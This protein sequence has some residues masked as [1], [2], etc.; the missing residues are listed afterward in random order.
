MSLC[1]ASWPLR[2]NTRLALPPMVPRVLSISASRVPV[3]MLFAATLITASTPIVAGPPPM[4]KF[5]IRKFASPAV[6]RSPVRLKLML[7]LP[8]MLPPPPTLLLSIA[9][10]RGPPVEMLARGHVDHSIRPDRSA[11]VVRD[12]KD[13][14]ALRGKI[15]GEIQAKV[16]APP[17][18]VPLAKFR[19]PAKREPTVEILAAL[20]FI[21]AS[22]P[23]IPAL[24][25]LSVKLVS[26][27]VASWPLRLNAR[28]GA[29]ADRATAVI[30]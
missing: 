28:L 27:C 10:S 17:T 6:V 23:I 5:R 14:V 4:S 21:P 3:E 30:D 16:R 8:T 18:M 19:I 11:G 15:A 22:T 20:T 7:A 1:V 12:R 29:S 2:L 26:L 24:E 25:L 13:R 9:A